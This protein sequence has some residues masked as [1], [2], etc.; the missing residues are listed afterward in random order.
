M[1]ATLDTP[2]DVRVASQPG[3][4]ARSYSL[5]ASGV[6]RLARRDCAVRSIMI[7]ASGSFGQITLW[8]GARRKI[9][10]QPSSFTGSFVLDGFCEDGLIVEV[11]MASV[12]SIT[13]NWREPDEGVV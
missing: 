9:W 12:P 10:S 5:T 6:F 4:L 7:A 1:Y 3:S 2:V 13:V 11:R 8:T